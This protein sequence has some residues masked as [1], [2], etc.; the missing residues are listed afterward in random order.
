[1]SEDFKFAAKPLKNKSS[2]AAEMAAQYCTSQIFV[3]VHRFQDI[4][5]YWSYFSLSTEGAYL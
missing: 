4:T 5:D 3:S 2:A 1:V